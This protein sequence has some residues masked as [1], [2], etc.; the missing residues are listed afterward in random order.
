M[1]HRTTP[2]P[3]GRVP[4]QTEVARQRLAITPTLPSAMTWPLAPTQ[5]RLATR[6][7]WRLQ[8]PSATLQMP[9]VVV[10]RHSA[11]SPMP[12]EKLPRHLATLRRL[13]QRMPWHSGPPQ[14]RTEIARWPSA[15]ELPRPAIFLLLWAGRQPPPAMALRRSVR[16]A[17]VALRPPQAT[18][19][20]L[21]G[22]PWSRRVPLRVS[23]SVSGPTPASPDRLPLG[24]ARQPPAPPRLP[25]AAPRLSAAQP[26]AARR[27]AALQAPVR[28]QGW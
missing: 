24:R 28:P 19:S 5:R 12:Q 15:P 22:N 27:S 7:A 10:L 23:R 26:L 14:S 8:R 18:R 16:T 20:R 13:A 17:V 21:A 25:L 1:P 11:P 4:V 3:S 9:A 2:S 6:V